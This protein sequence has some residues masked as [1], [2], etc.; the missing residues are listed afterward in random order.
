MAEIARSND[1]QILLDIAEAWDRQA[2][3]AEHR[4]KKRDDV[5]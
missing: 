2:Q 5:D 3:L 4:R 1:K